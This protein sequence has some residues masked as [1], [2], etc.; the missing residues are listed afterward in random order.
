MSLWEWKN[1]KEELGSCGKAGVVDF[2]YAIRN[3]V[4]RVSKQL[5]FDTEK[6][7]G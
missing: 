2:Y 1:V 4:N 6:G 3:L 7:E 5:D